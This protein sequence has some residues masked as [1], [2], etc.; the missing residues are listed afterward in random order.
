MTTAP[1]VVT[2]A[3]GKT[4]KRVLSRLAE[5]GHPVRPVSRQGVVRFDWSERDTWDPVLSGARAV[6]LV[7]LDGSALTR[8]F[9]ERARELGVERIVLA[10]GR[11][12]DVPG[13]VPDPHGVGEGL[14]DGEAAVRASGLE[15]TIVRP[16]WFAQNFSEGFFAESVAGGELR[17]AGG[18]GAAS[19]V[20]A[21]DIADV[22]VAAL[23]GEGHHEQCYELSGPAALTL[24]EVAAVISGATGRDIRYVPLGQR[25]AI[26]ELTET[27]WSAEDARTF[28]DVLE[29]LREGRDSHRSDGVRRALGREPRSFAEFA[30]A[31]EREGGW[32]H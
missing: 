3:T 13:Y 21:R 15:W 17:L 27:G 23:T 30:H 22:A 2:G 26:A 16:G 9:V 28:I 20:D 31:T 5:G 19:F 10:S 25:A 32:P 14:R 29:P 6:Y 24:A 4:G 12:I 18:D 1:I 7:P 8:P 11:G